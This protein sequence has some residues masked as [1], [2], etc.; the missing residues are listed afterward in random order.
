MDKCKYYVYIHM[1][2][3]LMYGY[4]FSEKCLELI[5]DV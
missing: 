4:I 3:I 1:Q 2:H 5:G